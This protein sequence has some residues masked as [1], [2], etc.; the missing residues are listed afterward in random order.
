VDEHRRA[1]QQ[2]EGDDDGGQAPLRTEGHRHRPEG[3]HGGRL[4]DGMAR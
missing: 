2:T 1:R 3:R 4:E